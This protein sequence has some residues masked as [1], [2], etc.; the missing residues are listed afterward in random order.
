MNGLEEVQME[1]VGVRELQS[2]AKDIVRRVRD[3]HETFD[4]TDQG[5]TIGQIVP[6]TTRRDTDAVAKSWKSWED[7]FEKVS[8]QVDDASL[9]QTMDEIRRRL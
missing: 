2:H 5:E 9:D 6:L 4:L 1:K 3:D 7:F 8:Q